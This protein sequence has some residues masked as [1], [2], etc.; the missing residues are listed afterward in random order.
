MSPGGKLNLGYATAMRAALFA[1]ALLLTGATAQTGPDQL[2]KAA[3]EA[4][5]HGDFPA[6]IRDYRKLLELQP[7]MLE[8]KVNL[9]AALV[10]VGQFDEA[11]SLYRSVLPTIPEKNAV[12]LN[13]ALAY[14][15]KG[16]FENARQVLEPMHQAQP[17][18]VQIAIL[19]AAAQVEL[20][21]PDAAVA[22][23]QPLE[24]PN[25]KNL[26]LKYALGTA[27]I[28]TGRP[29]EGVSRV[30]EVAQSGHSADAYLLAG[31]TLL[32][33]N[34]FEKARRD[35]DT[36]L[37]LD[38][39]LPGI[40]TL[41]GKARD[42]TGDKPAAEAAFRDALRINPEDFEANLYLGAILEERRELD[43]AK[44]YLDRALKLRPAD[45]MARY[46]S[47]M[48]DSMMG[49]YETAVLALETL[50]KDDPKWLEPHVQLAALYYKMHRSEDGARER[51]V[52]DRLTAEQQTKGPGKE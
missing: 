26:D 7:D 29:R 31:Q 4:Q 22:V 14:F 13:L 30:E 27:L 51:Q 46:E 48:L 25:P 11:I 38:P 2:L 33:L 44:T 18:R 20:G 47:A 21:K 5:M 12:Q 16:D 49:R 10:H 39:K 8:A 43:E 9:A 6:A 34:E 3:V 23:L 41:A 40:Q 15:K 17:K 50:T 42:K 45:S 24:Q 19:L 1:V 32:D 37:S 36:A 28:K 35:L 52:V